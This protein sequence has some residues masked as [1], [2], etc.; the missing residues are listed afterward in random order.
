MRSKAEGVPP[1][2]TWPRMVT[3]VSYPKRFTTSCKTGMRLD[4]ALQQGWEGAGKRK[5]KGVPLPAHGFDVVGGDGF[6]LLV[7]GSLGHDDDVQP[8]AAHAGLEGERRGVTTGMGTGTRRP[9]EPI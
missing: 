7:D 5:K 9:P 4:P 6:A 8:R 2:W 1:R 3:R